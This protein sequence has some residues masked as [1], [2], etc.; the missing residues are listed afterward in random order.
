MRVKI[1][2]T[3]IFILGLLLG[4]ILSGTSVNAATFTYQYPQSDLNCNSANS[5][6]YGINGS[7]LIYDS[8]ATTT[9]KSVKMYIGVNTFGGY[10]STTVLQ[11]QLQ[12][13]NT[14]LNCYSENKQAKDYVVQKQ[15]N[16]LTT[17]DEVQFNFSGECTIYTGDDVFMYLTAGGNGGATHFKGDLTTGQAFARVSDDGGTPS[18]PYNPNDNRINSITSPLPYGTT[19]ATNTVQ[20]GVFWKNQIGFDYSVLPPTVYGWDLYDA[21]TLELEDSYSFDL[22]ENTAF[23]FNYLSTTTMSDGSKILKSYMR[24]A[25][26]GVDIAPVDETFFNVS[27]NTYLMATG[28][29]SPRDNPAGLTQI[30]CEVFDIGCQFQKVL[31]FLFVPSQNVLDRFTGVWTRL[32][33]VKPF[34]YLT[35]ALDNLRGVSTTDTPVYTMPDIP[36][37]DAIFN[38]INNALSV[39]LWGVFAFVFYNKRLKNIDI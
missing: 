4:Y 2:P 15:G 23:V 18:L 8:N 39:I 13:N 19:T 3:I 32:S 21:V 20:I 27:T 7:V 22:D 26:T 9:I 24:N 12:R 29:L 16:G 14:F 38:P 5:Q 10:S 33:S 6:C 1:N 37:L 28:L 34:G 11:I 30:D 31:V 25:S 35:T 17:V 36:F